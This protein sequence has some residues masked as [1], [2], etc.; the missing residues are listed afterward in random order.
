M[1]GWSWW[2]SD[3]ESTCHVGDGRRLGFN[4]WVRKIPWKRP[5]QPTPVF[6]P[7]K[8]H[9]QRSLAGYSPGDHKEFQPFGINPKHESE[10]SQIQSSE[11]PIRSLNSGKFLDTHT[12]WWNNQQNWMVA[13]VENVNGSRSLRAEVGHN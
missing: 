7:G 8:S 10:K 12:P 9:G 6:L 4:P 13:E 3:K 5:R 2:L 1:D 11:F